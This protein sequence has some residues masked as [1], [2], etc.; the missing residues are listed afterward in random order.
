MSKVLYI[1]IETKSREFQSKLLLSYLALKAGFEVIIGR[2]GYIYNLASRYGNGVLIMKSGSPVLNDLT[3][4][5]LFI[6]VNDAEGIVFNDDDL[7]IKRLNPIQK[8]DH[9]FLAGKKQYNIFTEYAKTNKVPSMSIIGEPRFDLIN[10]NFLRISNQNS[11]DKFP[12][13]FKP[14][15]LIPTSFSIANPTS[16]YKKKSTYKLLAISEDFFEEKF[17]IEEFITMID[18]VSK[19]FPQF[20]FVIRPHPSEDISFWRKKFVTK[21]NIFIIQTGT[22]INWLYSSELVIFN[23]STVGLEAMLLRKP[24]INFK[25]H[26]LF[27]NNMITEKIGKVAYNAKQVISLIQEELVENKTILTHDHDMKLLSSYISFESDLSVNRML[28]EIILRFY[29]SNTVKSFSQKKYRIKGL[30][31]QRFK[32]SILKIIYLFD[33]VIY[34]IFKVRPLN[35]ISSK[36]QK[37]PSIKSNEIRKYFS[38]FEKIYEEKEVMDFK[39]RRVAYDTYILSNYEKKSLNA[40]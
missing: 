22:S 37:F 30:L 27:S 14:F 39:V 35:D 9:I 5:N 4:E 40:K 7:F 20:N 10:E 19:T 13:K 26:N 2:K 24:A 32:L 11:N 15:V 31:V 38:I 8:F 16:Y 12:N 21:K 28:Q 29:N 23:K 33:F 25:P 1:P 34:M 36:L 17:L 18:G 3:G 6:I